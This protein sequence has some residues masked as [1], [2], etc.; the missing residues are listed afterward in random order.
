MD[1]MWRILERE[2]TIAEADF[3]RW[4]V[5]PAA[6]CIHLCNSS[7][8]RDGLWVLRVLVAADQGDWYDG[9]SDCSR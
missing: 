8:Y 6:L 9:I 2:R 5:P 1:C 4:M 7:L 3:N